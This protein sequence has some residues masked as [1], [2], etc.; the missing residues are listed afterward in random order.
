MNEYVLVLLINFQKAFDQVFGVEM[1]SCV[2]VIYGICENGDFHI[3]GVF[4]ENLFTEIENVFSF[5]LV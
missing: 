5:L 2:L 1:D 3:L 4:S